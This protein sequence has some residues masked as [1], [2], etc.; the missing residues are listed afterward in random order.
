MNTKKSNLSLRSKKKSW[1][2]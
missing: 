1:D 2:C